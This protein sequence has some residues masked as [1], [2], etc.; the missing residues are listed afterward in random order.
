M[1]EKSFDLIIIGGGIQ[2]TTLSNIL[3]RFGAIDRKSVVVIDDRNVPMEEWFAVT[4]RVGMNYLRSPSSHNLEAPL[5]SLA[6]FASLR[7]R[8]DEEEFT[9][10]YLRPSLRLFNE[11]A[12][13]T[14]ENRGLAELRIPGRVHSVEI[15]RNGIVAI[16]GDGSHRAERLL[17]AVGSEGYCR[18]PD[19]AKTLPLVRH[20]FDPEFDIESFLSSSSPIIVGGGLSAVQLALRHKHSPVRIISPHPFRVAQFDSDPCFIGPDCLAEYVKIEG[21]EKRGRTIE[22]ARHPGS[23][24]PDIALLLEAAIARQ[25]VEYYVGR[26]VSVHRERGKFLLEVQ[27]G[28]LTSNN[29][30]GEAMAEG[31]ANITPRTH[32][33]EFWADTISLATGYCSIPNKDG[34]VSRIAQKYS[35]PVDRFGRPVSDE[36]LRWSDRIFVTGR[37][38][39]LTLGPAAPNIIG[40]HLAA[41]RLVPF[42]I[43]GKSRPIDPWTPLVI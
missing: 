29:G 8:G 11:H 6:G 7:G 3:T 14:I 39:E 22:A 16:A 4:D 23:I 17:L 21:S 18:I 5:Q 19:W 42:L 27:N 33:E 38:G 2:G 31:N 10:P 1:R 34:L 35:L 28:K 40:A 41:R 30:K 25:E 12:I 37:A 36:S 13:S 15:E 20:I 32:T 9:G 26:I 24:P 43:R